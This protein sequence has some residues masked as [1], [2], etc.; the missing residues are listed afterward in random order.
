MS[1]TSARPTARPLSPHLT[2]YQKQL[3]SVL[4][5]SHR[6]TGILLSAGTLLL[7]ALLWAVASGA[8]QY[9]ALTGVLTQPLG[10]IVLIGWSFCLYFH[11]CS[12]IR[13]LFWDAGCGFAIKRVYQAGYAVVFG[14]LVLTLLTWGCVFYG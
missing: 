14:A 6:I 7:V 11:L 2:I 8:T 9:A 5:I 1:S 3:T 4:S 12:G 13:H 10:R